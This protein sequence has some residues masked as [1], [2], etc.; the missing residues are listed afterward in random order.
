MGY[1]MEVDMSDVDRRFCQQSS[2]NLAVLP[3]FASDVVTVLELVD[4]ALA[5]VVE[6]ETTDTTESL[7]GQELHLGV[8]IVRIDETSRVN[9]NFLEVKPFA[10]TDIASFCPSPVQWSP[11]VV[12]R[13]QNSGLYFLSR[14]SS[15]SVKFAARPTDAMTGGQ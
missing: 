13:P 4:K 14:E 9:L 3:H 8:G 10:P 1:Y 5:L 2:T 6:Q 11:L 7:S 15:L 12:V